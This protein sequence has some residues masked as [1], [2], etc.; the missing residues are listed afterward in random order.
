MKKD[1]IKGLKTALPIALGYLPLGMAFGILAAQQ[2]LTALDVFFLSL[3][4]YAGSAQFIASAMLASGAAAAAIILTTFLVNL[5]HL[6]MSASLAPFLKHISSPVLAWISMGITDETYA[7]GYP[8]ASAGK[9]SPAFY[10]GLNG[11]SHFSWIFSTVFGCLLRSRIPNPE[12]WGLDFALPAM[13]IALLFIQLKN[14]K[15]ILVAL[16][17]GVLSAALA[18]VM[19]DNFNIIA[20]TVAAAFIGVCIEK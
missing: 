5:R 1:V 14:K 7:A 3:L 20:A 15:D 4:V 18:F 12:K 17:A 2:G 16:A 6:L 13:F 8:A 9:A 19:R 10:L 11:L